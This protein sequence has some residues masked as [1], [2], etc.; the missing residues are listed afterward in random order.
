MTVVPTITLGGAQLP[1]DLGRQLLGVSVE[2]SLRRSARA[3]ITFDDPGFMIL[4]GQ[5]SS[6]KPGT[7]LN[8]SFPDPRR[9][10]VTV[11]AGTVSGLHVS[12][13]EDGDHHTAVTVVAEDAAHGLG[14]VGRTV[15]TA[16]APLADALRAALVPHVRS[17]EIE[18]L[19]AG[20]REAV[21]AACSPLDL[22]EQV[23]ERYGVE[24]WVDPADGTLRVAPAPASGPAVTLD[25]GTDLRDL[26]FTTS[27]KATGTV[28]LRGWDPVTKQ[29]IA[30]RNTASAAP[31]G[32]PALLTGV[33]G[34]AQADAATR[35]EGRALSTA[36]AADITAQATAQARRFALAGTVLTVRTHLIQ[37]AVV[38]RGDLT[39]TGA[40]PMSGRHAVVAVRHDWGRTTGTTVV[41]GD[42][43]RGVTPADGESHVHHPP[44]PQMIGGTVGL[45][46]GLI[47][48]I[49]D[50]QNWGRVKVKL[51]TLG[52]DVETGWARAVLP[53]AGPN[54][55]SVVP[56][57]VDD[58]VLVGFEEGDLQ[59]PFVLGAVHNGR[60][61]APAATAGRRSDL[62]SGLTS[63]N[64][65]ALVLT[66]ASAPGTNGVSLKQS[67]GNELL[68]SGTETVLKAADGKPLKLVA[69]N[70][71]IVLDAQGNVTIKGVNVTISGQQGVDIKGL[72]ITAKAST[73]LALEGTASS[74]LKGAKVDVTAS[75]TASVKGAMVAIN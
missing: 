40:G 4:S 52:P 11:F 25:L 13:P 37:P 69:G 74:E 30:G 66:D 31:S 63:A 59:R 70:A 56:H 44:P 51:P 68:M 22:L 33:N 62:S 5:A 39:L 41:A 15:S 75:A 53:A 61:S 14:D 1:W 35:Y 58:E 8:I 17:V 64:G 48:D 54:R 2:R 60:D 71:S 72:R 38:P 21:I 43:S 27:G 57:R 65:H 10:P 45:L 16:N 42:R 26:D 67:D 12:C 18:G 34:F 29:E 7:T 28:L 50:P 55:G 20:T 49:H 19:P 3:E 6:F 47:C 23:C 36:S 32:G 46:P 73:T 24:W 9:S